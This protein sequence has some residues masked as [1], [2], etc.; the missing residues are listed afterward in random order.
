DIDIKGKAYEELV[1]ANLRGDRG[2]FFTP[3]NVMAMTVE[4]L[5]PRVDEKILDPSCGTGGF[6]VNS[7]I[8]IISDLE[9]EMTKVYGKQKDEW[10]NQE[11]G[12][13]QNKI[14]EIASSNF[15]GFDINPDLV[16]A[17]K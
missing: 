2:E 5:S 6:L 7:M 10:N 4:M 1:G 9:A 17:T 15:F 16:K 13:Y 11:Y 12:F 14:S 3:R 8:K